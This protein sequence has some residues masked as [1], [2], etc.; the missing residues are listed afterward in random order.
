MLEIIKNSNAKYSIKSAE[1]EKL[2]K[3]IIEKNRAIGD[4][5]KVLKILLSMPVIEKYQNENSPDKK[6][7]Y[8][9]MKKQDSVI[10]NIQTQ[11]PK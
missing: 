6:D 4:N 7:F 10:E 9:V 2:S 11:F 1:Y 3:S 5:H 8:K